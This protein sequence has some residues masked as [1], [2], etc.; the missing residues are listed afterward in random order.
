MPHRKR[1]DEI[2]G[3]EMSFDFFFL[4]DEGGGKMMTVLMAIDRA[5]RMKLCAPVPS[6]STGE[7]IAK[8]ILAFMKE[9]GCKFGDMTV[10]SDQEKAILAI[11]EKVGQMR[12]ADG[13]GRM[14]TEN[15]PVG[16]SQGNGLVERAIQSSEGMVR[17]MRSQLE[18]RWGMKIDP[19]H[20][21]LTW[22]VGHAAVLLNR[23][24]VAKDGKTAYE[25][26]KKKAARTLGLEFGEKV[27][28]KRKP[29]GGAL[30]KMSCMWEDGVYLGVKATTGEIII[31]T[32]KGVWKTRSVQRRPLDERWGPESAK[33]IG[34]IPWRVNESDPNVDGEKME[35]QVTE[36][37]GELMMEDEKPILDEMVVPR[38]FSI[39]VSDFQQ[40]GYTKNC[41]G[42]KALLK[43]TTR[44]R[45]SLGCRNRMEEALS[46]DERITRAK[47][48]RAEFV[49]RA[50]EKEDERIQ[51]GMETDDQVEDTQGKR[52]RHV[53][54]SVEGAELKKGRGEAM[55][56]S[57]SSMGNLK[58]D[59]DKEGD[60]DMDVN[61]TYV[62]E[63]QV[64]AINQ[65]DDFN[66]N[67]MD[68]WAMDDLTGRELNRE[69]V[70][71]A[72]EEEI[73]FMQKIGVYV[74]VPTEECVSNTGAGP[75]S[76][77]WID[78]DKGKGMEELIRSRL[79][80]RDFKAKGC[81][82]RPDLFAATPPL[83]ALRM[84]L[85]MA[86]MRRT[87]RSGRKK[88]KLLF[89]DVKKAHLNAKV[90]EGDYVYV[91]LPAEAN[92]KEGHCGRLL[93]WLYGTRNA[94][95]SW[96][97]EYTEKLESEGYTRGKAAP[98]T[99]FN[100][101]KDSRCVV[102]GDDFTFLGPEEELQR[103]AGLMASWYE[104]KV[105]AIMGPDA[106][107]EKEV[108]ILGR[109]VR[110]LEDR[111][112]YEADEKYAKVIIEEMGLNEVSNG[113]DGPAVKEKDE[114]DK[115]E[116]ELSKA[117]ATEFRRVAATANYLASDRPDL[118][119]ATKEVCRDMSQP[120]RR[121]WEKL[122]RI[123]RYLVKHP[124]LIINFMQGDE[125][126]N[127]Y[128]EVM[129]DSD[130]AGCLRT[131][132][133]TSGGVVSVGGSMLRSWSSTQGTV[134]MSSGEAEY[135]AMVKA[136]SEVLGIQALAADLGWY[137][138]ARMWVDST[139]AKSIASRTGLGKVRHLEVRFL[140]LQEVVKSGRI[141]IRKIPG[142]SNPADV[143]TK[144]KGAVDVSARLEPLGVVLA[145]RAP[146]S[147][148]SKG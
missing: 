76:V 77:R 2:M 31:G 124:R 73:Q 126:E 137:W 24:E 101:D 103:I 96:E 12:A 14:L 136:A 37:K 53:E 87:R 139:T 16:D 34:G 35:W 134:A 122:K 4:G 138:K 95:S 116:E 79:V 104:I 61:E 130:W 43:A 80:A 113:V 50:L 147:T 44:Q 49:D 90:D 123:A 99:F 30:G 81:G 1:S 63:V 114:D 47:K 21:V 9:V 148:S 33:M 59:R 144:P 20:P 142:V 36:A 115:A 11:L 42:C 62:L 135:Y 129:A 27:L 89:I 82:D 46:G 146:A 54:A 48:R 117:E 92:A 107:D 71:R 143:M 111:I 128:L 125:L 18:E 97:K 93:R 38:A 10:K 145:N 110:W 121:S 6:K 17:V 69:A 65:D 51:N 29:V 66:V 140:W 74:E 28:W 85:R 57:S 84:L 70:N 58:R 55:A 91:Q 75:L 78:T 8:R 72:R 15:S 83:E 19:G 67:I 102:H 106:E 56:A 7:F 25:R 94:A 45:H 118:Q 100:K 52:K 109:T 88:C 131:R 105:R 5:T 108:I 133:S 23:F 68:D 26:L 3:A 40:H 127:M 32:E 86:R 141:D 132:K 13:G 120:R 22:L 112:E 39:K 64:E 41:P 119:Y 60:D 98:T